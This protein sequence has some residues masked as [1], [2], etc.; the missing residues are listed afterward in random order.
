MYLFVQRFLIGSDL[1][2]EDQ[3]IDILAAFIERHANPKCEVIIVDPGRGRKN[4][5]TTKMVEYGFSSKH[6][7]P[8]DTSYLDQ[9]FKGHILT[10]SRT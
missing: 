8:E 2:Y 10:F 9:P 6:I 3:H 4:K 7:K 5:L 1:L